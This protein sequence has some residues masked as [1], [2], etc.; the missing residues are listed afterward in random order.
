MTKV[1]VKPARENSK[2][3]RFKARGEIMKR[4]SE[5]LRKEEEAQK[6]LLRTENGL[7]GCS[8]NVVKAVHIPSVAKDVSPPK[9]IHDDAM[10]RK[11][12][13]AHQRSPSKKW[14]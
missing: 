8:D 12:N 11:V 10:H 4:K 6:E 13:H 7:D 3:R 2:N 9:E 5:E 1:V 14:S